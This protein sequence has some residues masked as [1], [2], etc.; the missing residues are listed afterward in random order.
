MLARDM[1]PRTSIPAARLR[2]V[3]ALSAAG[4]P[5]GVMTTVPAQALVGEL[6]PGMLI[7]SVGLAAAFVYILLTQPERLQRTSSIVEVREAAP[8]SRLPTRAP[9]AEETHWRGPVSY[10]DAVAAAAPA[11]VNVHT[12]KVI[13]R[14]AHPLLEDPVFRHFFGDRLGKPRREIETSLGSGVIISSQGYVLTNNHVIDGA[15]EILIS[16]ADGRSSRAEL[17]GQDR[18]TDI[19]VLH[20]PLN[21]LQNI[22]LASNADDIQVGDVVLAIGNPLNVGQTV[23]NGEFLFDFE[24]SVRHQLRDINRLAVHD[25][26]EV[27]VHPDVGAFQGT[28]GLARLHGGHADHTVSGEPSGRALRAAM[29]RPGNALEPAIP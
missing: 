25:V 26:R 14:R 17:I 23:T 16:L 7:G 6:A 4:V 29:Q 18:E 9:D 1:E 11:I 5:V 8:P 24:L 19:A 27:L 3:Q 12:A 10:A 21:D 2:A 20:I 28:L 15:D 13:T 22:S